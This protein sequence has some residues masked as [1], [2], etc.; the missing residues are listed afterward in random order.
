[1]QN[2]KT[3][4]SAEYDFIMEKLSGLELSDKLLIISNLLFECYSEARK[5]DILYNKIDKPVLAN[6][7]DY[8]FMKELYNF[9]ETS[10]VY[11]ILD[12]AHDLLRVSLN[13]DRIK[14]GN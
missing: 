8:A 5:A 4:P 3:T 2:K 13:L 12:R 14:Y 1:M 9:E 6:V 7:E 10:F 11:V